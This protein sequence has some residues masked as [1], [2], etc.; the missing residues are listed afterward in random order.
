MRWK[1]YSN[2]NDSVSAVVEA[3]GRVAADVRAVTSWVDIVVTCEEC[4]QRL[5]EYHQYVYNNDG[6]FSKV[7]TNPKTPMERL[8]E[9]T[10]EER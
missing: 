7:C 1:V 3:A 8:S 6:T 9:V 5:D 4:G 10:L 2:A